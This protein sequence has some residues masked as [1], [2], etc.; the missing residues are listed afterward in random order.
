MLRRVK[1]QESGNVYRWFEDEKRG[2]TASIVS[3]Y[4]P[5]EL[6]FRISQVGMGSKEVRGSKTI[7]KEFSDRK[8]IRLIE[9][10]LKHLE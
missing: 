10:H 9:R 4:Y 3:G 7:I 8:L 5:N 1:A 2:I 6:N